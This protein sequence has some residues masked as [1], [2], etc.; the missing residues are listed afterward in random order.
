MEGGWSRG[1]RLRPYVG[2]GRRQRWFCL[3][4]K[5]WEGREGKAFISCFALGLRH[6]PEH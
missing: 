3:F 4:V 2:R 1:R 6:V 5:E